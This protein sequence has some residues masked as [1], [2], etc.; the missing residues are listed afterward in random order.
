MALYISD[1]FW[2]Q[3]YT[4]KSNTARILQALLIQSQRD[5]VNEKGLYLRKPCYENVKKH[6]EE[7]KK[8]KK[9]TLSYYVI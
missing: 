2:D 5:T 4:Y 6:Y 8:C 3:F 9:I 1:S 7:R